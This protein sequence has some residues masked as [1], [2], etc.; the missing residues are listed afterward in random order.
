MKRE[1]N[2]KLA[3]LME[4]PKKPP[5]AA[6]QKRKEVFK[7]VAQGVMFDADTICHGI[8]RMSSISKRVQ[9]N[10]GDQLYKGVSFLN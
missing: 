4:L 10:S 3:K 6:M 5:K 8:T 2:W 1:I 7:K 9:I